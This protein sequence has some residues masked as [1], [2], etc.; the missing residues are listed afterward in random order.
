MRQLVY[1]VLDLPPSMRPLVYD[2]GQLN[3]D[4]EAQYIQRIVET[5]WGNYCKQKQE[6]DGEC[7]IE[8]EPELVRAVA[9]V[10]TWSQDYMR[11]KKVQD[12]CTYLH[13][14]NYNAG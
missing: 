12:F 7:T 9:A 4:T 1:R 13:T 14:D 6:K 2:F 11:K 5:H 3:S 8:F 10:L